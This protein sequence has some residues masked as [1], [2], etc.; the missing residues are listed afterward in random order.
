METVVGSLGAEPAETSVETEQPVAEPVADTS[1]EGDAPA[2]S[3]GADTEPGWDWGTWDPDSWDGEVATLP[4]AQQSTAQAFSDLYSPQI[5][6]Q[7]AELTNL[8][9]VLE[10]LTYNEV[11]PRLGR[12]Q[13]GE[14]TLKAEIATLKAELASQRAASEEYE[15]D[16]SANYMNTFKSRNEAL[17]NNDDGKSIARQTRLLEFIDAGTDME[18]GADVMRESKAFQEVFLEFK[19]SGV[20]DVLA[21]K[22]AKQYEVKQ[23][24][25][26]VVAEQSL[27][28]VPRAAAKL[29]SN[30]RK[31]VLPN[32]VKVAPRVQGQGGFRAAKNATLDKYFS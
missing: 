5:A 29:V 27:V 14:T 13:E 31:T 20:S 24:K 32:P 12:L 3:G 25:A 28:P 9:E 16:V 23:G 21:L 7:K 18:I 17:F 8:K 22:Y 2:D 1:V 4:E 15:A 26:A 6:D 11:D 30:G 10:A 19:G